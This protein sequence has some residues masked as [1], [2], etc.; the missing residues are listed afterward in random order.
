[1]ILNASELGAAY[2]SLLEMR[3]SI[4]TDSWEVALGR[5]AHARP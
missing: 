4:D 5:A 2:E 1:M 3:L